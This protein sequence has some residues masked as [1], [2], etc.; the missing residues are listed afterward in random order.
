MTRPRWSSRRCGREV[1]GEGP[2]LGPGHRVY[3]RC[4]CCG[5]YCG[6]VGCAVDLTREAFGWFKQHRDGPLMAL[7]HPAAPV[8]IT[9]LNSNG[10]VIVSKTKREAVAAAV[11]L[12]GSETSVETW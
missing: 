11:I 5:R 4:C 10:R 1:D 6:L 7:V 3:C 12:T 8:W 2:R 9:R